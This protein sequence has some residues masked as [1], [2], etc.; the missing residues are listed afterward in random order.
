MFTPPEAEPTHTAL[1]HR[2]PGTS[3][4][5][6]RPAASLRPPA[7]SPQPP[8][9]HYDTTE[10]RPRPPGSAA[11]SRAVGGVVHF[12]FFQNKAQTDFIMI[13]DRMF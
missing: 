1:H 12:F 9:S 13:R 5:S 7:A 6:G 8:A 2:L 10:Q 4:R 3:V 11:R